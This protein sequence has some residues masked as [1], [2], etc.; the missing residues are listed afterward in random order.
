MVGKDAKV[1]KDE[2]CRSYL[3]LFFLNCK[4][5][6]L[7]FLKASFMLIDNKRFTDK[8]CLYEWFSTQTKAKGQLDVVTGFF[9]LYGLHQYVEGVG[10]S[11]KVFRLVIGDLTD[12]KT[13]EHRTVN[14]LSERGLKEGFE[15]IHLVKY[16]VAFLKSETVQ[17]RTLRPEFCHAKYYSFHNSENEYLSYYTIGS[18]NLTKNGLGIDSAPT[19]NIELNYIR[20]GGDEDF[21][22]AGRWFEKLWETA[23]AEIEHPEKPRT[24]VNY[25]EYLINVIENLYRDFTPKEIYYKILYEL[26]KDRFDEYTFDPYTASQIKHLERTL[27]YQKLYD[28]QRKGVLSLIR[29]LQKYNGAVLADAVGLGKTWSA[30]AVMKFF[31]LQGYRVLMLCPKKLEQN[32]KQYEKGEH[33][34]FEQDQ[35]DYLVHFHTDMQENHNGGYRFDESK[36]RKFLNAQSHQ[37]FLVVIDESHNLRNDKSSR[38]KILVDEILRKKDE[39][40]VLLLSATPINN[41]FMDLRNQF[42]LLCKGNDDG[43]RN[44]EGI[45]VPN[46]QH[47]FRQAEEQFN[48]WVKKGNTG[49]TIH[50]LVAKL[51]KELTYNLIDHLVVARTRKFIEKVEGDTFKFPTKNKPENIYTEFSGIGELKTENDVLDALKFH[52]VGYQPAVFIRQTE[53]KSVLEDEGLRQSFL[54]KMMYILLIKRLESSWYALQITATR[55]RDHHQNA[56]N[57]VNEYIIA[58]NEGITKEISFA[59]VEETITDELEEAGNDRENTVL[60]ITAKAN[61]IELADDKFVLGK[62]KKNPVKLS[63]IEDI[64]KY[65]KLLTDDL[66]YFNILVSNLEATERLIQKETDPIKSADAKLQKLLEI[67]DK[68][69]K[70]TN[71]KLIIFTTYAD[72]AEY[73]YNQLQ[74]RGYSRIGLVKG[75]KVCTT[76]KLNVVKFQTILKAFAPQAKIYKEKDYTEINA[77][78]F[79]S[80]K[81][82]IFANSQKYKEEIHLLEHPIDILIATDCI[83]EGQNLQDADMVINYDIHWNPTRLIQR[84]GRIDRLGSTNEN[85]TGVN[86]WLGKNF[87]DFLNLKNRVEKRMSLLSVV[88][89]ELDAELTPELSAI[90][91]DNPL[92]SQQEERMMNTLQESWDNI[93]VGEKTLGLDDLTLEAFRQELYEELTKNKKLY[94]QMPNGAFSALRIDENNP[95]FNPKTKGLVALMG[96]PTKSEETTNHKYTKLHLA[97]TDATGQLLEWGDIDIL[98]FL[99]ANKDLPRIESDGLKNG[100]DATLSQFVEWVKRWLE[101]NK[102]DYSIHFE[103]EYARSSPEKQRNMKPERPLIS[104]FFSGDKLDL[105]TWL[106]INI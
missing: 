24:K 61:K 34:L 57:L 49:Q 96:Y 93:E 25:K 17:I 84:M 41:K 74:K 39:V 101:K 54:V 85:I 4:P 5:D 104:N 36:L 81:E 29:M 18:A 26:F 56:L 65:Q 15:T 77:P 23:K 100:D 90:V 89:V 67:I 70:A 45:D 10:H 64:E 83:S 32:W 78:S 51:P 68:K 19:S 52:L 31:E 79:E 103:Q 16:I 69:Q 38:Y 91:A 44:I 71:P 98:K 63:D 58:R 43:F 7:G 1:N 11:N 55:M 60:T 42:K 6:Y 47:L 97:F 9:S 80:W 20:V 33:S 27:I 76:E 102:K 35:F 30:L 92:V 46:L 59:E 88:G 72:T 62:S 3:F 53:R 50:D 75:E 48:H 8:P 14:L 22:E 37:K 99:R 12:T 94:E 21:K 40:K 73:L 82:T 66:A 2:L 28:F 106:E 95:T 87:E 86:F 13:G 105:L